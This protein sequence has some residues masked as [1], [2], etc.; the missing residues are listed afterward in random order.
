MTSDDDFDRTRLDAEW[1]ALNAIRETLAI[2]NQG[3]REASYLGALAVG[4]EAAPAFFDSSSL[5]V[6]AQEPSL[7]REYRQKARAESK[8]SARVVQP[9]D[10]VNQDIA[11]YERL[12]VAAAAGE[13]DQLRRAIFVR[14]RARE[15]FEER[16]YSEHR[17]LERDVYTAERPQL[18]HRRF[19]DRFVEYELPFKRALRLRLL[20]PDR[21]EHSTGADLVYEVCDEP[22][23]VM[24]VAFVQYKIWDGRVLR[25]SDARNL[26]PQLERLD[27][28]CCG[29]GLCKTNEEVSTDYRLPFCAAFLRPTDQLQ[30]PDAALV[31]SGTHVPVCVARTVP[32][33]QVG[34]RAVRNE[35]I[36][37]RSLSQRV[38][39]EL[40]AAGMVGSRSL[41]YDEAED[42]YKR[43]RILEPDQ[44]IIVHAQEYSLPG[45]AR[46]TRRKR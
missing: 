23:R 36:R 20:H 32:L 11:N 10:L 25:F 7:V 13:Q 39:E 21:P 12:L 16:V 34:G 1:L 27:A 9:I 3:A 18:P 43:H 6:A 33:D 44:R 28:V 19:G 5:L 14:L 26:G 45:P 30:S 29:A 8:L 41:T 17:L 15:W 46:R 40:F 24:R 22:N 4:R 31:S 42:L 2:A 35:H 38:F 37:G